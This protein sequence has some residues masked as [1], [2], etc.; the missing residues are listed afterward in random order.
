V[1]LEVAIPPFSNLETFANLK[2]QNAS[3]FGV[4]QAETSKKRLI[5]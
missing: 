3:E 1:T 2:R 4:F 5:C